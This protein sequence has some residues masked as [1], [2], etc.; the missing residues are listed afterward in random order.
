MS[1]YFKRFGS[2]ALTLAIV[3]FLLGA[4]SYKVFSTFIT[5]KELKINQERWNK[6]AL[7][8]SQVDAHYVDDVDYSR[9][10]EETIPLI[11]EKLDPHSLYL[12]PK[13]LQS[14]EEQLIGNFDGIGIQFNVPNDTA[15]VINVIS[16]GP[17]ERA[18]IMS[19]DRIVMVDK[20]VVAG[21]NMNQDSLVAKLRGP[22]GTMVS[23]SVKR[24]GI[25]NPISFNIKRDKI[26]LKSLDVSYMIN[27]TTG[28]IKLSKFTRTSYKEFLDAMSILRKKGMT[29]LIFDLR[30]NS[31]GY[32]DQALLLSNEFLN[33]GELIV[34]M[35]GR[36]RPRQDFHA[37]NS[38][39][40]RDIQLKILIDE[41][42]ASSS[43]IVAGAIQDNDRGIIVGRRSFGKG[44]VQEPVYFSDNSG[45]R[46]TVARFYTPTGR[47]IQKP[48][49]EDNYR[50]DI[51]E[52][53]R[54]GEMISADSIRVSDSLRFVTPGGK[55]VFG[56][57]GII[58]DIFVPI[59]TTGVTPFLIKSSNLGLTFKFSA[60]M[61]DQFRQK[62]NTITTLE[63]YHQFFEGED[64]ESR[65]LE[66]ARENGV[67]APKAEW[68]ES[69]DV[70]MNHIKAYIGRY[71]PLDDNAFYPVLLERDNF[72]KAAIEQ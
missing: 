47:S 12:T 46:L 60:L 58:P 70:I 3:I 62:I 66:Y 39:K 63:E 9:I 68:V 35:Q 52:R 31:G 64:F 43:E 55:V 8:L 71:T 6:L 4:L 1:R 61:A 25:K 50:E 44:L 45:I 13:E 67:I 65:F 24:V 51:L 54:H 28:Y 7:I 18:G 16:G 69:K 57:G 72:V 5:S 27:D 40:Y 37:D 2:N 33:R 29:S 56:G 34:Y 11:L 59:D 21:N 15:V 19:G 36:K 30:G 53:Y 22:S 32:F 49:Q 20:E 23:V 41:G 26:P 17:S 14:A 48:Y 10:T 42:S 38:G